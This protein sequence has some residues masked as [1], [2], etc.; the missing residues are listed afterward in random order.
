MVMQTLAYKNGNFCLAAQRENFMPMSSC[1]TK[2]NFYVNFALL[3]SK[4]NFYAIDF[5]IKPLH[6]V[7][8]RKLS[9]RE[10]F[11]LGL[12]TDNQRSFLNHGVGK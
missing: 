4:G 8:F 1:C 10:I 7:Q 5:G 11:M 2:G 6:V 9:L 3:Y 12:L